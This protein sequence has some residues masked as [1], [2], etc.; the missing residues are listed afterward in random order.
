VAGR[1]R[2]IVRRSL[3]RSAP[4]L[5]FAGLVTTVAFLLLEVPLGYLTIQYQFRWQPGV[6][7]SEFN[8]LLV[9]LTVATPLVFA[10]SILGM[11]L[12]WSAFKR[13]S[14]RSLFVNG[15]IAGSEVAVGA[16]LEQIPRDS[17]EWLAYLLPVLV[18]VVNYWLIL[19]RAPRQTASS[20]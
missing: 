4:R 3:M 2:R 19:W 15:C 14:Y 18:V 10:L 6:A 16:T 7:R 13:F 11:T 12:A 9:G 20:E 17:A 1:R 8:S 5:L